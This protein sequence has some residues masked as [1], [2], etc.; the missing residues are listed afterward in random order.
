[1]MK[2][3]SFFKSG[4]QLLEKLLDEDFYRDCSIENSQRTLLNKASFFAEVKDEFAHLLTKPMYELMSGQPFYKALRQLNVMQKGYYGLW[5][6]SR[7]VKNG[8]FTQ[9]YFNGLGRWMPAIVLFLE[10]TEET[11]M[12]DIV[13]RAQELYNRNVNLFTDRDQVFGEN[14]QGDLLELRRTLTDQFYSVDDAGLFVRIEKYIRNHASFFCTDEHGKEIEPGFTGN[15]SKKDENG[16]LGFELG[17][18]NGLVTDYTVYYENGNKQGYARF[19]NEIR[20][21]KH[22]W[23]K[24]G[25]PQEVTFFDMDGNII[26]TKKWNADGST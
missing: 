10:K 20:L 5:N 12:T 8:G 7:E 26:Q 22:L 2:L 1:M 15:L 9:F 13:R 24:D 23:Y 6:M 18:K 11:E 14:L 4:S 17:V 19:E 21:E 3:F 16:R 25:Q